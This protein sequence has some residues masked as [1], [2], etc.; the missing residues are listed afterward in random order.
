M[1]GIRKSHIPDISHLVPGEMQSIVR[2]AFEASVGTDVSTLGAIM[3]ISYE[4]EVNFP[5]LTR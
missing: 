2:D 3:M 1:A 5:H 4:H